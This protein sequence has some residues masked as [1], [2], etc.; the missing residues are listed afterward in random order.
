MYVFRN[1]YQFKFRTQK[2]QLMLKCLKVSRPY[3][4]TK[5]FE[6]PFKNSLLSTTWPEM[7]DITS[8]LFTHQNINFIYACKG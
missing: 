7:L 5:M 2:A 4:Y 3:D 6:F 8:L 1:N